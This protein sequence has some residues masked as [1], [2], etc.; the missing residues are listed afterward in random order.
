MLGSSKKYRNNRM[1][2]DIRQGR[3]A[4]ENQWSEQKH[5]T[6]Y[7]SEEK[8]ENRRVTQSQEN[9]ERSS[10]DY[11]FKRYVPPWEKEHTSGSVIYISKILGS[12]KDY[13][14][15]SRITS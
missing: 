13:Q 5:T 6:A 11:N 3:V 12:L 10:S 4:G 7:I 14:L 15:C 9:V 8:K 2:T 1:K